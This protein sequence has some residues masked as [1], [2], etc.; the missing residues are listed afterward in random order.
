M[1][2]MIKFRGKCGDVWRH[3]DHLAYANSEC[4]KNWLG[5]LSFEYTAE[6]DT[7][8]QFT[9]LYDSEGKEIY[10]GDICEIIDDG[11][12]FRV[13]WD[14]NNAKFVCCLAN[15]KKSK[16]SFNYKNARKHLKV[17]G[18]IFDNPELLKGE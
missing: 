12:E 2:R 18:N 9:G 17:I 10:E 11:A 15:G 1:K 7:V 4:I 8:G 16:F 6:S 5:G 14:K 3:G 13:D